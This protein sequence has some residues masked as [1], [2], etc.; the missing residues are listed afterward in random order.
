MD[1]FMRLIVLRY[2]CMTRSLRQG[3]IC[4]LFSSF[5]LG[6]PNGKNEK[7]KNKIAKLIEIE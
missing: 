7:E 6:K 5:R 2:R 3:E 1:E 4:D